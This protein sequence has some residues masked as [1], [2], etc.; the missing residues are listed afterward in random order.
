METILGCVE[1]TKDERRQINRWAHCSSS[2]QTAVKLMNQF[3]IGGKVELK[4]S[5]VHTAMQLKQRPVV[6]VFQR[7]TLSRLTA[8]ACTVRF[9]QISTFLSSF[10]PFFLLCP[11]AFPSSVHLFL[12]QAAH[13]FNWHL[14]FGV[15]S[16]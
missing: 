16:K 14:A 15:W 13:K 4:L 6:F 9:S 11:A 8:G 5:S 7:L 12:M 1:E 2:S 10:P 3:I